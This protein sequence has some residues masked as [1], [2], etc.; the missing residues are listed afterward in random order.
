MIAL[1]VLASPNPLIFTH[2]IRA[3]DLEELWALGVST[4]PVIHNMSPGW[5]DPP[6][7]VRRPPRPADRRRLRCRGRRTP[8]NTYS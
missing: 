2:M 8:S 3:E 4:V 7:A 5:Q 1:E 6:G